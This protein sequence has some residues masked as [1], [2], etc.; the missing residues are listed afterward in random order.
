MSKSKFIIDKFAKLFEQGLV[1]YKDLNSEILNILRSNGFYF[2]E[3][4]LEKISNDNIVSKEVELVEKKAKEIIKRGNVLIIA[5]EETQNEINLRLNAASQMM[6][7]ND[8]KFKIYKIL[9]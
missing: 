9:L 2:A 8:K 6:G 1:S 4:N 3:V 7:K 5:T